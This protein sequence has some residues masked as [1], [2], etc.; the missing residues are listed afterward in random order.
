VSHDAGPAGRDR[1]AGSG[2]PA[3]ADLPDLPDLRD[4]PD[5]PGGAVEID[6]L[7]VAADTLEQGAA[8]CQRVLGAA[9]VAGGKHVGRGSHNRLLAIGSAAYPRA[10]LEIIAIDPDAP[11]PTRPRWFNLDD[12]AVRERLRER[13]RLLHVV[14]RCHGLDARLAALRAAGVD[15]GTAV[16]AERASP[17]GRLSWRIAGRADGRLLFGGALPTLIEWG[18]LHPSAQLPGSP[19]ALAGVALGGLP[20]PVVQALALR[21]V[22]VG[23]AAPGLS[24]RLATPRG[25]VVLDSAD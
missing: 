7:V 12:P 4:L 20:D 16:A 5:L 9:P 6:H 2:R 25:E 15:P 8:W 22:D 21:G 14:A 3:A 11:P 23:R 19:V 24:A 1:D 18:D 13:P 10:Y 17:H